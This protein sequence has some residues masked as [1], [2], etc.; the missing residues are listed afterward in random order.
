MQPP[1]RI[2]RSVA[3]A[4]SGQARRFG[5]EMP[6]DE[7]VDGVLVGGG[8]ALELQAHPDAAVAPGDPGLGVD[9]ALGRRAAGSARAT[10]APASS[11]LVVRMASPPRL[12]LSVSAAAIV[13]PKRYATGMPRTTRGL[14]RRLKLSGKRCGASDGRMCWLALYSLT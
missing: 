11:G 10:R 12:R 3:Q 8:D 4:A 7:C 14:S 1:A 5:E 13:L 6:V 9:V 2:Y